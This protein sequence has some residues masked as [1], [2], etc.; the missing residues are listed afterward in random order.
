MDRS[1]AVGGRAGADLGCRQ[2]NRNPL[3]GS[4]PRLR[5]VLQGGPGPFPRRR[6]DRVG[7]FDRKARGRTDGRQHHRRKSIG[8]GIEV[9]GHLAGSLILNKM[10]TLTKSVLVLLLLA[11]GLPGADT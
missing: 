7:T 4:A 8:Q 10:R 6:R 5:T 1:G 3:R 2:R 9:Y 11:A